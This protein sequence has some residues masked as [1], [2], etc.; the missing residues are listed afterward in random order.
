MKIELFYGCD[1]SRAT[2]DEFMEM[3]DVYLRWYRDVRV[4]SDLDLQESHAIPQ[5]FGLSSIGWI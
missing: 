2:I 5:G 3:L 4:K 1:W